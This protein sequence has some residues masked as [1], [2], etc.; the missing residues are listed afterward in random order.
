MTIEEILSQQSASDIIEQLKKKSVVIPK[1]SDLE[2]QYDPEQHPV[3]DK[4][5]Y[6]DEVK[7]GSTIEKVTRIK[8]G[9]QKLATKRMSELCFG[10]PVKRIYKPENDRQKEI[11]TYIE[12]I[13]KKTRIDSVNRSRSR[14]LFASCEVAT[15]WFSVEEQNNLYGFDS[16]IKIKC[17]SYSPFT[18]DVIYP[19]F[20]DYDDLI[21]L[22]FEYTRPDVENKTITYFD[23]YTKDKHIRYVQNSSEWVEE[24][25]EVHTLGKIPAVYISRS[26]PIWENTSDTIYEMEWAL[27]R[28]GNYIRK[29]AKPVLWIASSK[30]MK[31]GDSD[32][33]ENE[34]ASR[35]IYQGDENSKAE[36]VTWESANESLKLQISK[37]EQTFFQQLQLPDW[38]FEKLTTSQLSGEAMKQM[39]VDA[40]LKVTDESGPLLEFLD[41]EIN[42]VKAFLKAMLPNDQKEID[43]LIVENEITPFIVN[44]EKT[45]IS[46]LVTATGGK[47][48]MSQLEGISRAGYSEN[49]E[50]TL[51]QIK[52][53]EKIDALSLAI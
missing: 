39:L 36:Y 18:G 42:V 47:A 45:L 33:P 48:V 41:R 2:K 32:N 11:Q 5:F 16:K 6:P 44:D 3:M 15:L 9:F 4:A 27:S 53:E 46:N 38:S 20:D 43:S 8:I 37:L 24:V 19:L 34:N 13:F 29:N 35:I 26:E 25:N 14:S 10:I 28:N 22:S 50:E 12:N 31:I 30:N 17:R 52:E 23:T 51:K 1:W 40:H 21:A 7:K 49:P